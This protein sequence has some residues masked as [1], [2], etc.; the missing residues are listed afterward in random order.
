MTTHSQLSREIALGSKVEADRFLAIPVRGDLK[1]RGPADALM[2]EK[3][4]FP[5][6]RRCFCHAAS[7]SNHRG[8]DSREIAPAFAV[9]CVED[10][11]GQGRAR[12]YNLQSELPGQIVTK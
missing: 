8:R 12:S 4:V 6:C 5:K 10:K 2:R 3:H 1:N 7:G 11:R 9:G